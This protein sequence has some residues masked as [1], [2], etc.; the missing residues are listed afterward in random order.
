MER[1]A[2]ALNVSQGTIS[3]DLSAIYFQRNKSK[4]PCQDDQQ[5]KGRG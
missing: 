5:S 1:I 2:E 4:T 3:K